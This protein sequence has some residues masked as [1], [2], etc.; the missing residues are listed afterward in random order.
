[1]YSQDTPDAVSGQPNH[2]TVPPE[3]APWLWRLVDN[4]TYDGD[5]SRPIR[6]MHSNHLRN[7]A[8]NIAIFDITLPFALEAWKLPQLDEPGFWPGKVLPAIRA[9]LVRRSKPPRTWNSNSPIARLKQLKIEDVAGKVTELTG[10]G[11]Q[12]KG[13]CPLHQKRTPS[14]YVYTDTQRWRCYGACAEGGDVVDLIQLL[15]HLGKHK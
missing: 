10:S 8:S 13:L 1:M 7:L 6:Y 14:F 4:L 5:I 15:R 9:E 11:T 12:L 3:L 2:G